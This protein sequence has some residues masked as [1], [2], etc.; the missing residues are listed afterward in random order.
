MTK[1][2]AAELGKIDSANKKGYEAR[3]EAFIKE[4]KELEVY[5]KSAFQGKKHKNIVTMHESLGYFAQAFGL[6]IVGSI[7]ARPGMDPNANNL[8][9]LKKLSKEKEV[10]LF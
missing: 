4:L 7:Q 8:A 6:Q 2:I 3:A 1:I 5:G 10:R 9:E